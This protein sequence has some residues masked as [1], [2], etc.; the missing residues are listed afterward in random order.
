ML[1]I[2]AFYDKIIPKGKEYFMRNLLVL[3]IVISLFFADFGAFAAAA[4]STRSSVQNAP[5]ATANNTTSAPVSARAAVRRP[6]TAVAQPI[7]QQKAPVSARAATTR[8]APKTTASV[9]NTTAS[10]AVSARAGKKQKAINMGTKVEEATANTTV[11]QECQDAYNGCMDSFCMLDNISGGRCQCSDRHA[12]LEQVLADIMKL[13]QRSYLMAT[14]GVERLQMGQNVDEIMSRVKSVADQVSAEEISMESKKKKRTLDLSSWNSALFGEN[15]ELDDIFEGLGEQEFK[16]EFA[17]K[18]GDTLHSAAAKMCKKSLPVQCQN[19]ASMLQLV[20]A[21]KIKSDC[22]AYENSLKKQHTESTDKLRQAEQSLRE[23]ALEQFQAENKYDLGSCVVEF[24]KCMQTTAE[25]GDDFSG[26]VADTVT[27]SIGDTQKNKKTNK[28]SSTDVKLIDTGA[29]KIEIEAATYDILDSKK[30]M[31]ESVLNSCVK[32][33]DQV[34]NAFVRDIAPVI[35]TAQVNMASNRRMNCVGVIVD[36]VKTSC[37]SKWDENTD[38]Y[39][40]CIGDK[41]YIKESCEIEAQ[42]CGNEGL[43]DTVMNYVTARLSA[44]KVDRCTT[45]VKECLQSDNLC[46]KD[47]TGCLGIDSNTILMMC[48]ADKLTSCQTN[49]KVGDGNVVNY[50]LR[51]AQGVALNIHNEQAVAC[52]NSVQ[53]AIAEACGGIE[54]CV[55][56]YI[57]KSAIDG[58]FEYKLCKKADSKSC[59]DAISSTLADKVGKY[60]IKIN[61]VELSNIL[62][63]QTPDSVFKLKAAV[64][65][66]FQRTAV[67]ILIESMQNTLDLIM[68]AVESNVR[69]N[70][71]KNGANVQGFGVNYMAEQHQARFPHLTDSTRGMVAT[72]IYSIVSD[73]YNAKQEELEN[74]REED[75][76]I[77]S[78]EKSASSAESDDELAEC[79]AGSC[80]DCGS[81]DALCRCIAKSYFQYGF[82]T[83][84]DYTKYER[85]MLANDIAT[86]YDGMCSFKYRRHR[87]CSTSDKWG[88]GFNC[89]EHDKDYS[90]SFALSENDKVEFK[91]VEMN[92]DCKP[93]YMGED[94]ADVSRM[95]YIGDNIK[96]CFNKCTTN[97]AASDFSE[98]PKEGTYSGQQFWCMLENANEAPGNSKYIKNLSTETLQ[99]KDAVYYR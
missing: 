26:C 91:Q 4:R 89:T 13:D 69:V 3:P 88:N 53:T 10:G 37:G 40:A 62:V 50:V 72:Q 79:S 45:Q 92:S 77:L 57:N 66:D 34:W 38:N 18:T 86:Y 9:V 64:K 68:G 22:M 48:P 90:V 55:D 7:T 11:S 33:R 93:V 96:I 51:V 65:D 56:K 24:K 76:A 54:E 58:A 43:S 17:G 63:P 12:E 39:D 82:L 46:G 30:I 52:Q 14:E 44:M 28:K 73:L 25:C 71:C 16:D 80:Q 98:M 41:N 32:V 95:L 60:E 27:L 78:G 97:Y 31:C 6:S 94:L 85:V 61:K 99:Q 47:Y 87:T 20:Y 5:A 19:S 29:T 81:A 15:E 23:T 67:N 21:Q 74:K 2:F 70:S 75:S 35:K 83:H 42:K 36:C 1:C 59:E 84:H 49:F 8:T